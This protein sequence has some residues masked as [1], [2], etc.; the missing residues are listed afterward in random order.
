MEINVHMANTKNFRETSGS[1]GQEARNIIEELEMI[2]ID[3][4]VEPASEIE[5]KLRVWQKASSD[6][7]KFAIKIC[8]GEMDWEKVQT[9]AREMEKQALKLEQEKAGR[10]EIRLIQEKL[11]TAER[12][13]AEKERMDKEREDRET[14]EKIARLERELMAQKFR[15]PG[16]RYSEGAKVRG[17]IEC[18]ACGEQGHIA[19]DCEKRVNKTNSYYCSQFKGLEKEQKEV[20]ETKRRKVDVAEESHWEY[21]RNVC[22]H[23][24]TGEPLINT[25]AKEYPHVFVEKGNMDKVEYCQLEKCKIVTKEGERVVKNGQ[26]IPQAL[27]GRTGDYIKSLETRG[28]IRKSKSEWRNPMRAIEK[29]NGEVRIV[30]NLMALNDL[31]V[32]DPY[33]IGNIRDV[34]RAMQGSRC[35]TVIDLQEGFYHIEIEEK[36]KEK[37]AFEFDG[38]VYEWNGMV[39]GFKNAPQILQRVMNEILGDLYGKGVEVYMDDIVI[40]TKEKRQHYELVG[41]VIRRLGQ[42]NMRVNPNKVQWCQGEIQLLGVTIDGIKQEA[43]EVKKNEALEYPRPTNVTE[44]R[45]FLGLTGYFRQFIK[46][47]ARKTVNLT[48][49][50]K[51]RKKGKIVWTEPMEREFEDVK[52]ALREMKWLILP[53]YNKDFMLRTDASN[54]GLGAVLLQQDSEG[55]WRP[56]Q[57]ASKKLTVIEMKYGI[58]EKEM[59]AVFWGIMKFAYELR[60]RKFQLV[61]DHKALEEIRRKPYFENDRVNRWVEKI[62]EFDFTV[63]YNK[64]EELVAADALS[65]IHETENNE[66]KQKTK[67]K[68]NQIKRGKWKTHV[69]K[70]EGK[71]FWKFDSGEMAEIPKIGTRRGLI[72][73]THEKLQHRGLDSVYYDMKSK[74]Y[75]PGMK[76][77]IAK[78]MRECEVCQINN[79]KKLGGSEFVETTRE[80]EKVA[81]DLASIE[82]GAY[83][84]IAID[85]FSRAV[86]AEIIKSKEAKEITKR[87][88]EWCSDG[89]IPE[90]LITDNG[91]E[92]NNREFD[93]LCKN[94]GIIHTKVGV[95]SHRSNGR[96]ER[97]IRTIRE[98]L[99]KDKEGTISERMKRI[100][101]AYNDTYH[102]GIKCTPREALFG[103][104]SGIARQEN[105]P[106]GNYK[107][108]FK[109]SYREQFNVGQEV[110]VAQRENLGNQSKE[111][112]G[113]FV[114]KAIVT[115]VCGGDSY[116]IKKDDGRIVKKRHYDLKAVG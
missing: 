96:V 80:L 102:A 57:W 84:L 88:T 29:P 1:R 87:I 48:G 92:F 54:T 74:W 11:E 113:R 14:K 115:D 35:F 76:D 64:G 61:T 77:E 111:L 10:E 26:I 91:R 67:E 100:I 82:E 62:Q 65:R 25:L 69:V 45:R 63:T 23:L 114:G 5:W 78:E 70:E 28:V 50:T 8:G 31:V 55:E 89:S 93:L 81:L 104:K 43:S 103:D 44:L 32:K 47:Y 6:L 52:N 16:R 72:V 94:L 59:L 79:R 27:K 110:R 108:Q 73:D 101:A 18:F 109:K 68:G 40:H 39:M 112:K 42:N 38:R 17:P 56:V 106:D 95:E 20:N 86:W 21:G 12:K 90:E 58:T 33:K 15:S 22:K 19:R 13:L 41:E 107:K 75:W 97:V 37:T 66:E 7:K 53:D 36:D 99:A 116:L 34:I 24:R 49:G 71:E 85:Y 51:G 4:E 46:D 30:S 105:G 3:L 9:E 83:G 60:G 2:R 98:G